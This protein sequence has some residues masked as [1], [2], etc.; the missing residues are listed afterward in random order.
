MHLLFVVHCKSEPCVKLHDLQRQGFSEQLWFIYSPG[1]YFEWFLLN[2]VLSSALLQPLSCASAWLCLVAFSWAV[3]VPPSCRTSQLN[4]SSADSAYNLFGI[5]AL[6]TTAPF[7]TFVEKEHPAPKFSGSCIL[8]IYITMQ[9]LT[10][11]GRVQDFTLSNHEDYS[12]C[13]LVPTAPRVLVLHP[14]LAQSFCHSLLAHQLK[15]CLDTG[16][17]KQFA[18]KAV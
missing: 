16:R 15:T 4:N 8:I 10:G 14:R 5:W 2:T 3:S 9:C 7:S 18:V 11:M 1:M 13:S 12:W 6:H 17:E